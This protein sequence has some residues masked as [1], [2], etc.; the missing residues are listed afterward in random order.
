VVATWVDNGP[1]RGKL[2]GLYD[3]KA[4]FIGSLALFETGSALCGAA[5]TMDAFIVGRAIC[6]IGAMGMFIGTM[7]ILSVFTTVSER[8]VYIATYLSCGISA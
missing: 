1:C 7:D 6:G 3:I 2:F 4:L 8:P 5:P